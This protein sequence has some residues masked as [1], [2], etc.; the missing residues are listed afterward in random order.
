[1]LKK[2]VF[3]LSLTALV[4]GCATSNLRLERATFLHIDKAY[5]Q[6]WSSGVRGGG[7]GVNI[8]I[9]VD[10][11]DVGKKLI[12]LYFK[13]KYTALKFNSPNIYTGFIRTSKREETNLDLKMNQK[14]TV[15]KGGKEHR[16][17]FKIKDDE[18]LLI[19]LVNKKKKY[20]IIVL[21]KKESLN[22]PQ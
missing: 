16:P 9:S 14:T 10:K 2:I 13:D 15:L 22:F 18:A 19:A 8:H 7:S 21:E 4:G 3:F 17:P 1:M 11:E 5:Y 20:V 12:G 6:K